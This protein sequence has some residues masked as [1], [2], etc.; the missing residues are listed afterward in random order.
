M[1]ESLGT[2]ISNRIVGEVAVFDI[3]GE[4]TRIRSPDPTLY[5]LVRAQLE[6]GKR[7]ILIN[8]EN[9]GFVDTFAVQELIAGFTSVQRLGGQFRICNVSPQLAMILRVTGLAP[10][11]IDPHPTE[12]AAMDSFSKTAT[13]SG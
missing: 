4:F 3:R 11:V 1:T 7:R 12:A 2:F 6:T 8:F 10:G 5:Q 9:V 13:G